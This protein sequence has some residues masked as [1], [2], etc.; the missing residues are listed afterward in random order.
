MDALLSKLAMQTVQLVGKAAFG[1]ASSIAMKRV[2]QYVTQMQPP[3]LLGGP[4][5]LERLQAKFE[6]KLRVVTPAIDLIE[7]ISARGHSTMAG[8]LQLTQ[9]LRKDVLDFSARLASKKRVDESEEDIVKEMRALVAKIDDAVP[10]LNLALT[11]SGV[12]LGGTLP[13][14]VSPA[15]LMQA[16]SLLSRADNELKCSKSESGEQ[17]GVY[18]GE[19]F[20][21]RLYSLFV[22][23]VRPKM[24]Q[25]FT[26]KEEFVLCRAAI[27]R[28]HGLEAQEESA[29]FQ[30][31]LRVVEDLDDGRYHEEQEGSP[32]WAAEFG[33]ATGDDAFRAGRVLRLQL[34]SMSSLHYSFA[35]SLL[36]IED[37]NSPV[38]VIGLQKPGPE[39]DSPAKND[40]RNKI[41]YAMEI[42]SS[43]S[44]GSESGSESESEDESEDKAESDGSKQVEALAD[45]LDESCKI[46]HDSAS[47]VPSSGALT[48][49]ASKSPADWSRCTLSLLEYLIR[50]ACVEMNEQMLHLD[51]HDERLRLYLLNSP[52]SESNSTGS[53]ETPSSGMKAARSASS[54]VLS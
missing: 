9:K 27:W 4:S 18:V 50:L 22:G 36:N 34:G 29:G 3:R 8:V 54:S 12:H 49:A 10:L 13:E 7:L 41:W 51:V 5:E 31:E 46:D 26:W 44:R 38:L 45:T 30:Y 11:T 35:G 17:G 53:D 33:R 21:L 6:I 39:S 16:S 1:A 15:R 14:G 25:D 52:A 23:S 2:T 24:R 19:P 42:A 47:R 40:D 37:S 32:E 28:S 43:D 48:L 20:V